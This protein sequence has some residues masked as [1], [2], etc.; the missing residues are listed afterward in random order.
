MSFSEYDVIRRTRKGNFLKQIDQ[1]IDWNPIEEAIAVYYAPVSDAAGR[2]AYS[3]L[4]LFKILLVG[5]WNGGLSD[6]SAEDMANSN[7]HVMRFLGLSLEDD[8]PDHS[9]LSRFRTRLTA[10]HAWDK[11]L[12]RVNEQI[13]MHDIMVRKDWHVDTSITQNQR[14][15]KIKHS[16]VELER[17]S[18]RDMVATALLRQIIN[19]VPYFIFAKDAEGT[20]VLANECVARAYGTT[21]TQLEGKKDV[22][23][24]KSAEEVENFRRDDAEVMRTGMPKTIEEK[25]TDAENNVHLLAITKIPFAFPDPSSPCVLSLCIDITERRRAEQRIEFLAHHDPLTGLANRIKLG[26]T[27][28]CLIGAGRPFALLLIDLD[29]FKTINDS[30]G[31]AIGDAYLIGIARRIESAVGKEDTVCRTGGDEFVVVLPDADAVR[32]Q[33]FTDQ[34]LDSIREPVESVDLT[35][36]G[37]CS[38]GIALYPEHGA[39]ADMLMRYADCALYVVRDAG[40]NTSTFFTDQI[41][42]V[43]K[44]KLELYHGLKSDEMQQVDQPIVSVASDRMVDIEALITRHSIVELERP[45]GPDMVDAALLRQVIDLIPYF[46][47]AK[48][49]EGTYV[50]ANECVARAY[51]TTVA[52]LEGKKDADF[53]KSA[54][55]T[56]NFRRDD[57]E[58]M[59]TGM[60]KTIEEKMTDAEN[61]VH[62]LATTKIPFAFPDPSSPC[63]LGLCIDIT[64]QRRAEQHIEFLAYHDPLTGLA[65]RIQLGTTLDCLIGAGRPFALLFIDLDHFKT[66]NDSLGHAIGDAYLIGIARRLE[67]AV[68]KEDTVYRTGGDEFVVVLPDVDAARAQ[69]FT[70]QLLGSINEP[71]ESADLTLTGSCSVGIALYPEHGDS[72]DLLMRHADCALYVAKDVG[73]N[74]SMFFTDQIESVAKRKLELYHG[75]KSAI[76]LDEIWQVYQPI[77]SAASGRI[78]GVEAL[79]RWTSGK[80]GPV[81]PA[82]FIPLAESTGLIES[83][84]N[85]TMIEACRA[86]VQLAQQGLDLYMA[87]NISARQLLSQ[88]FEATLRR[89]CNA[90]GGDLTRLVIEVTEGIFLTDLD[91]VID[92]LRSL[93]RSGVSVSVDDFGTGYS[94]LSYLRKLPIATLKIDRAFVTNCTSIFEDASIVRTI[95]AMAQ[96]LRL[97]VVAEGVENEDQAAFLRAEGC[98]SLQGYLYARPMALDDLQRSPLLVGDGARGGDLVK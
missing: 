81:S 87:V 35:L 98:Q 56:A 63:I 15:P 24:A 83:L 91:H 18:G 67:S 39:S 75:L 95:L 51:G 80:L 66:I 76:Q 30:L 94:S 34:L 31:H 26:T 86:Q 78:I 93:S 60:P 23:F 90:E 88:D 14:K 17:P 21:V 92:I 85:W 7:L 54:V 11:L 73:R 27:L 29:H 84:G 44:R 58:V 28:D 25:M 6:E 3:G 72:A 55:E 20:F 70:D 22:D 96:S 62:L 53:E 38:I 19:L 82:E 59:R 61:N 10:A 4:L 71:V 41:E 64:E 12:A 77:V 9:V 33:T 52:Q 16:I 69:T 32:A 46:I 65:N 5:I 45:P 57:S 42:R 49:A 89:T 68:G 50:L 13:Q 48:D 36:T 43:A 47:F 97:S 74:T 2:P 1:L 8:V 79:M 40:R 37:S